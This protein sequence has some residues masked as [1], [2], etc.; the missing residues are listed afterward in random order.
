MTFGLINTGSTF[1]RAMDVAFKDLVGK[2]IIIYMDD[3]IVF[4]KNRE[5]HTVDL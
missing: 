3:L 5:D 2:F 4:L 1:Q